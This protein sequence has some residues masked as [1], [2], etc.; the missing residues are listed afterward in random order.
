MENSFCLTA[1]F[2]QALCRN[3]QKTCCGSMLIYRLISGGCVEIWCF[4]TEIFRKLEKFVIIH[5]G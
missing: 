4:F 1:V 5:V 2:S 3:L